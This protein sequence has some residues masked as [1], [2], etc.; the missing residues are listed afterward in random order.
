M[1][2]I[3]GE[4]NSAKEGLRNDNEIYLPS[5]LTNVGPS[6]DIPVIELISDA[7]DTDTAATCNP[8]HQI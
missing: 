6:A 3:F 7:N 4:A 8:H 2:V 5:S 1:H